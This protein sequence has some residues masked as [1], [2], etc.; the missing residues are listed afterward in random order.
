MTTKTEVFVGRYDGNL[1]GWENDTNSSDEFNLFCAMAQLHLGCVKSC[2]ISR[3][4]GASAPI[5][6]TGGEDEYIRIFNLNT[7]KLMGTLEKQQ[8]TIE[9]LKFFDDEGGHLWLLSGS[10]DGTV[11]VWRV[12]DWVCGAVLKGH[13]GG[14]IDV[15]PHPSGK[16]CLTSGKDMT[17]RVWDLTRSKDSKRCVSIMKMKRAIYS[18][19]FSPSG[20]S[21]AL[22]ST[23]DIVIRDTV[24]SDMIAQIDHEYRVQS[25]R[26]VS[27]DRI[28]TAGDDH[29]I[30]LWSFSSSKSEL[31]A[32]VET[33]AKSRI[34]DIT[35]SLNKD[36]G[37]SEYI[38]S[39]SSNGLVQMWNAQSLE[40]KST[41][42]AGSEGNHCTCIA[43]Y[44]GLMNN[45][46][47]AAAATTT[48]TTKNK[49]RRRGKSSGNDDGID[50][51][52]SEKK[53]R[54]RIVE[55]PTVSSPA[56]EKK[57]KKKKKKKTTK[58]DGSTTMSTRKKKKNNKDSKKKKLKKK[59]KQ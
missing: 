59:K 17:L 19:Q 52:N 25:F 16:L 28:V 22:L 58:N 2:A 50:V 45:G 24:S 20:D 34:R 36:T 14:V 31:I 4:R 41:V 5:L 7:R 46:A 40:L 47:N 37:V 35:T 21:Y 27:N 18:V 6:A 39:V 57:K 44:V 1:M 23:H 53:K 11:C 56:S 13:L 29:V 15:A 32:E 9:S 54:V 10:E 33:N 55:P 43:A 51:E 3:R 26:F 48:T 30:R 38:F 12:S 8:G 49:K 42:V